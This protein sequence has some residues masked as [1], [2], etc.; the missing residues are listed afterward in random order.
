MRLLLQICPVV[1]HS[2]YLYIQ[3]LFS[4]LEAAIQI[5]ELSFSRRVAKFFAFEA[6]NQPKS[7]RFAHIS[8]KKWPC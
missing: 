1:L 6:L 7:V 8:I 4:I 5:P 2:I 3:S